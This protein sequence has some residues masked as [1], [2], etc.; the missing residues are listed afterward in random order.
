MGRRGTSAAGR[1]SWI[2]LGMWLFT[3]A[4]LLACWEAYG[5]WNVYH[6]LAELPPWGRSRYRRTRGEGETG[7]RG[8]RQAGYLLPCAAI[9]PSTVGQAPPERGVRRTLYTV[10]RDTATH[11]FIVLFIYVYY[12]SLRSFIHLLAG[13]FIYFIIHSFMCLFIHSFVYLIILSFIVLFWLWL[14]RHPPAAKVSLTCLSAHVPGTGWSRCSG[15]DDN[16]DHVWLLFH[17]H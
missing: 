13:S 2:P 12:L 9:V 3:G 16:T 5:W 17:Y 6:R 8:G 10:C 7:G 15:A 11:L 4:A 1:R 14:I